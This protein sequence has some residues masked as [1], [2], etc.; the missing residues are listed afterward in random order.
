MYQTRDLHPASHAAL[1]FQVSPTRTTPIKHLPSEVN[2]GTH[3][4]GSCFCVFLCCLLTPFSFQR[5]WSDDYGQFTENC[6]SFQ[7]QPLHQ[8]QWNVHNAFSRNP[9]I[10]LD[11]NVA[12]VD[13]SADSYL[14]NYDGAL[15]TS[16]SH[17]VQSNSD[18]MDVYP[19]PSQENQQQWFSATSAIEPQATY[20]SRRPVFLFA[21]GLLMFRRRQIKRRQISKIYSPYS[22]T[23][24]NPEMCIWVSH[25]HQLF[26]RMVQ[27]F[28][29]S[30]SLRNYGK[31]SAVI[32]ELNK[33]RKGNLCSSGAQEETKEN[34]HHRVLLQKP[35][36]CKFG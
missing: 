26:N 36:E 12:H 3:V 34:K 30:P 5:T 29:D 21:S 23:A 19:A 9:Q 17:P 16:S 6:R 18:D 7:S 27:K 2:P 31:G 28:I 8:S 20:S 14:F 35:L 25:Q 1:A 11:D 22:V 32:A 24:F 15:H 33:E 4:Y 10:L 13:P